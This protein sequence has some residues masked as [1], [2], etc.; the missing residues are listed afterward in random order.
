MKR[1]VNAIAFIF[2]DSDKETYQSIN[3]M[4]MFQVSSTSI[5]TMVL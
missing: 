2:N 5:V 1:P 4:K 3:S